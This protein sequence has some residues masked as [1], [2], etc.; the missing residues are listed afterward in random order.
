M[1]QPRT[2]VMYLRSSGLRYIRS[3]PE[4]DLLLIA[5]SDQHHSIRKTCE[6]LD[7]GAGDSRVK[8]PSSVQAGSQGGDLKGDVYWWRPNDLR[9][10]R[11]GD[12]SSSSIKEVMMH[13]GSRSLTV[14][15]SVY[16]GSEDH[17][18][19]AHLISAQV[20]PSSRN[21][22]IDYAGPTTTVAS[23]KPSEKFVFDCRY[24]RDKGKS[25]VSLSGAGYQCGWLSLRRLLTGLSRHAAMTLSPS[26][27]RSNGQSSSIICTIPM[28]EI[29]GGLIVWGSSYIGS[30]GD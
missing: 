30:L 17:R 1:H 20:M 7:Y 14:A 27:P 6:H 29:S 5:D 10:N 18:P 21:I 26:T 15:Q 11:E 24:L 22:A 4:D 19:N 9:M 25:S 12:S 16:C 3:G 13:R 23:I 28:S 8:H 2:S